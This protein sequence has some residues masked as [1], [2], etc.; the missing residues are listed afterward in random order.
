M[1]TT[2][3]DDI[4]LDY[5]VSG[6][7]PPV[8]L[9]SGL[10]AQRPFWGLTRPLLSGFTLVEFDN[11]DIGKSGQARGPYTVADMARD[12]LAVLDAAGIGKAHV[13][14]HSMGGAIAQELAIAAPGRVDRLVLANSFARQNLYTRGIM[15]LFADLRRHVADELVFGAGLTS[16]VLG[17]EFLRRN[18]LYAVVQASLDAGLDQPKAAFLRQLEACVASDTLDRLHDI[19]A[20]TLVV[21]SDGD[22]LFS[23]AMARELASGI[24]AGADL[25]E[26][27]DSGH[28]PMVEQP[29]AFAQVVRRFLG[30]G[31]R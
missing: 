22:R 15:R 17:E 8:L 1:P 20:P 14:G 9:I 23:P 28:C 19:K 12:A 26:I 16:F 2:S 7:G 25:D 5:Q 18:D 21:Y 27:V 11:R 30:A 3:N 13:V 6:E 29:Q 31:G 24:P 4:V 10:S